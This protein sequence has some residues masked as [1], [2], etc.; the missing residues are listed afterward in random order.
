MRP[1]R[2]GRAVYRNSGGETW[3]ARGY[4]N[5]GGA[6]RGGR[7]VTNGFPDALFGLGEHFFSELE[8]AFLGATSE[9]DE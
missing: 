5:S 8:A 2:R 3:G 4:R 7:S 1:G 9:A 6:E